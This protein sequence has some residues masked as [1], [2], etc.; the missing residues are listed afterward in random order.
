MAQPVSHTLYTE[1][2]YLASE[3][4][5]FERSEYIDGVI[6]AMAGESP[7]HGA[8]CTNLVALIATR[9]RG[10]PCQVFTKDMKVRSGP[11]P[12]SKR[13]RKGLFSYP[14]LV[15]VCGALETPDGHRDVLLNPKAII[16]VLSDSTMHFDRVAKFQRYQKYLPSLVDYVLV[17]QDQPLIEVYHRDSPNQ[18]SWRYFSVSDPEEAITI[19]SIDC[20]LS[21]NAVYDRVTFPPSGEDLE[22]ADSQA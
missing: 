5:A 14:D 2:E 18:T 8:I 16:E 17:S 13:N 1:A 22:E 15:V 19:L 3:R 11:L 12:A 6:Y 7:A 20:P 21:L 9:L 4:D 10:T